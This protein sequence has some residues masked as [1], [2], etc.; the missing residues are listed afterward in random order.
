LVGVA[1]QPELLELG[2]RL[3]LS[4]NFFKGESMT[5]EELKAALKEALDTIDRH[6]A[7]KASLNLDL[8]RAKVAQQTAEDLASGLVSEKASLQAAHDEALNKIA[9]IEDM[10]IPVVEAPAQTAPA[11]TTMKPPSLPALPVAPARPIRH[12]GRKARAIA[13]RG[14]LVLTLGFLLG[15]SLAG[16]AGTPA[17]N[18]LDQAAGIQ[19][20]MNPDGTKTYT[21]LPSSPIQDAGG[22]FGPIGVTIGGLIAGGI[23][24][25]RQ[26]GNS[27]PA[28]SHDALIAQNA[29]P[30][31]TVTTTH[32]GPI[33]DLP[34]S[35]I[36]KS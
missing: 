1:P 16:C 23:Y 10:V 35:G 25:I 19:V 8:A 15:M 30:V 33:A 13:K 18:A 3:V 24:A 11:A 2:L 9:A 17:G 14:G 31:A 26:L 34:P 7:E 20:T 21:K 5:P 12:G 36:P 4:V 28:K 27:V 22:L 32:T 29:D 6:E